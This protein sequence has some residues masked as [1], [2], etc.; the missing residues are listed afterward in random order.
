M[1][2]GAAWT[3]PDVAPPTTWARLGAVLGATRR[4]ATEALQ[5][6]ERACVDLQVLIREG[7]SVADLLSG[8]ALPTA[9]AF[10]RDFDGGHLTWA[11]IQDLDP[12]LG[13]VRFLTSPW[14]LALDTCSVRVLQLHPHTAVDAAGEQ[15]VRQAWGDSRW[16]RVFGY[17]KPRDAPPSA[18]QSR[19]PPR[20]ERRQR[21]GVVSECGVRVEGLTL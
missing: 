13:G 9:M 15:A 4:P 5:R 14:G 21:R 11:R 18:P 16:D 20:E 19:A 6:G 3:L 10:V 2:W 17:P 1:D 12:G 8:V 7:A